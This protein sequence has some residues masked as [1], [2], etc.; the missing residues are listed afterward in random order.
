M[1]LSEGLS[2]AWAVAIGVGVGFSLAQFLPRD[3]LV[4][5]LSAIGTTAGVTAGLLAVGA[6]AAHTVARRFVRETIRLPEDRR[7]DSGELQRVAARFARRAW[8]LQIFAVAFSVALVVAAV[9][10]GGKARFLLPLAG[11][12]V[13]VLGEI[14][15]DVIHRLSDRL[16]R[17]AEDTDLSETE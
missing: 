16:T 15:I 9:N 1:R 10:I 14:T 12:F 8:I 2:F 3:K 11:A 17:R 13:G 5:L 4:L 6:Y 7:Y